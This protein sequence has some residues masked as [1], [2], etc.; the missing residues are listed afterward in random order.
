M[1]SEITLNATLAYSDSEDTDVSLDISDKSVTVTTKI[2]ARLKQNIGITE[3]AIKLGEVSSLGFCM[4][5]NRDLTNFINIKHATS[6]TIIGKMLPGESY[7]PVRFGSGVT[8]PYAIA[9][10][11]PCQM[12]I[13]ICSA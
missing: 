12:D 6:G 8:A 13:L 10:T 5:I 2:V 7:G 3:E 4:F 11:A 9:D 1:A